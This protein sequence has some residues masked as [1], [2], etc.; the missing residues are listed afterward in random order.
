M[1]AVIIPKS[2]QKINV[3]LLHVT[4]FGD[5]LKLS[6]LFQV[7][8]TLKS[9]LDSFPSFCVDSDLDCLLS[10]KYRLDFPE[11]VRVKWTSPTTP[12]NYTKPSDALKINIDST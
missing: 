10:F 11:K 9:V 12:G 7:V 1:K 3:K 6:N 4:C 8:W 2:S 5:S